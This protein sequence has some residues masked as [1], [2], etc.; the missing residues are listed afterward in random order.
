M[1]KY[2]PFKTPTPSSKS[3]MK[4]QA[5]LAFLGLNL[6]V[7]C[8]MANYNASQNVCPAFPIAGK[9]VAYELESIDE[10]THPNL[11]LWLGRL[12]K[13]KRQLSICEER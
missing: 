10:A 4:L 1:L 2:P 3:K 5:S 12:E 6:C 9:E 13:L 7:A 11:W 8:T